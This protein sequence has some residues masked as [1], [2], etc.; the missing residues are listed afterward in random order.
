MCDAAVPISDRKQCWCDDVPV[1]RR[2][3]DPVDIRVTVADVMLLRAG[4]HQYLLHWQRHVQEDGGA[5]HSEVEHAE[6]RNRV[7]E[8][9]WR[10]ERAGAPPNSR[11]RHS[12]EA[13]R[14]AGALAPADVESPEWEDQAQPAP[15]SWDGHAFSVERQL[16]DGRWVSMWTRGTQQTVAWRGMCSCG[17]RGQ[18]ISGVPANGREDDGSRERAYNGWNEQHVPGFQ[19]RTGGGQ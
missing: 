17:W 7:G 11:V 16:P 6:L 12:D 2:L 19:E 15:Q 1:T 5:T 8:L 3:D 9:I 13:V 18:E 10:L 14:P 4:L